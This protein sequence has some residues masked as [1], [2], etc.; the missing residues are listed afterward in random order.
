MSTFDRQLFFKGLITTFV[1]VGLMRFSTIRVQAQGWCCDDDQCPNFTEVQP[2]TNGYQC[3]QWAKI[4]VDPPSS[5]CDALNGPAGTC[6]GR[7]T[8]VTTCN[9]S[10][11]PPP[12][13]S[14]GCSSS[15]KSG[16]CSGTDV[17]C[18]GSCVGAGQ[19][20]T[21]C[22]ALSASV[23]Q[24]KSDTIIYGPRCPENVI[25]SVSSCNNLEEGNAHYDVNPGG[26]NNSSPLLSSTR[27]YDEADY[28]NE[29]AKDNCLGSAGVYSGSHDTPS[30]YQ[31]GFIPFAYWPNNDSDTCDHAWPT[32][33]DAATSLT[34]GE[35]SENLM[36]Q[37]LYWWYDNLKDSGGGHYSMTKG[38]SIYF[39]SYGSITGTLFDSGYT[40]STCTNLQNGKTVT[41]LA[42]VT[43]TATAAD[44]GA[45]LIWSDPAASGLGIRDSNGHL[46]DTG[47]SVNSLPTDSNGSYSI[48]NIPIDDYWLTFSVLDPI[49]G[50]QVQIFPNQNQIC[51]GNDTNPT[52]PKGLGR[53][54]AFFYGNNFNHTQS[55]FGGTMNQNY[56]FS[57][58]LSCSLSPNPLNIQVNKTSNLTNTVDV[59]SGTSAISSVTFSDSTF[60]PNCTQYSAYSSQNDAACKAL[61]S[62]SGTSYC[63]WYPTRQPP[64]CQ[65]NIFTNPITLAP[66]SKSSY[67]YQI[68]VNAGSVASD[69]N[70]VTTITSNVHLAAAPSTVAISCTDNA[71]VTI[72][73][74][75]TPTPSAPSGNVPWWQVKDADVTTNGNI[76]SFVPSSSPQPYFDLAG[77]GGFPGVVAYGVSATGITG[78][79]VSTTGWLVN[80]TATN[81]KVYNYNYFAN[82]IPDDII[83]N[84]NT[85]TSPTIGQTDIDNGTNP[86][87]SG[88][89]WF[90][91]DGSQTGDLTINSAVSL[92][93]KKVILFVDNA[94]L[95]ITGNIT[96]ADSNSFF[97]VVVNGN[98]VVDPSVGGSEASPG[99]EGIYIAD[100][101]FSDGT[102]SPTADIPLYFKGSVVANGTTGTN[103]GGFNLQ[104]DLGSSAANANPAE[105]F[106]YDPTQIVLYPNILGSRTMSWKE[107]AP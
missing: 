22:S 101:T 64:H 34:S 15:N 94:N 32:I 105:L 44:P 29:D 43:V 21:P 83:A 68:S 9:S 69:P 11:P 49:T 27:T 73:A 95:N 7:C 65:P 82:L 8:S 55:E 46:N 50:K 90:K 37:W 3:T 100:G 96:L 87:S 88:Y 17:C 74:A 70:L 106:E 78:A 93:N 14:D 52:D 26:Y 30:N 91:Y 23:K 61:K 33:A 71:N 92:T 107:V 39:S 16:E 54:G 84:I 85:I 97:M 72:N 36:D 25:V 13:S 86:D 41:P 79:N 47:Y 1:F 63:T 99:L 18:A 19:C 59:L 35:S 51:G 10:A 102:Q 80:S 4:C 38:I 81:T 6:G 48:S 24:P 89:Y 98:I 57:P 53:E 31:P 76:Q 42:G 58:T 12:P 45:G 103:G 28:C 104:R 2:C 20:Y 77:E 60:D 62:S 75:P 40:G 67:P 5:G 56:G 66:T